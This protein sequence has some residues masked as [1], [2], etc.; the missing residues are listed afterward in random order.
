ME[1]FK[2]QAEVN[3][4]RNI[5]L[6]ISVSAFL[7]FKLTVSYIVIFNNQLRNK[8]VLVLKRCFIV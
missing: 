7:C 1:G 4:A 8:I 5:P 2:Q 6:F 3:Y